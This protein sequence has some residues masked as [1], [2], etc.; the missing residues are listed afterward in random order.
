MHW[1][2]S[3]DDTQ[4]QQ[5]P[6]QRQALSRM[7][8]RVQKGKPHVGK[9]LVDIDNV[10][11]YAIPSLA[12]KSEKTETKRKELLI[13]DEVGK[14]EM[15]C[16]QFIPAVEQL[17]SNKKQNQIVLGTIPTP[18]Y[19]RVI[20]AVEDIRARED[21]LV[22]HVTKANRDDLTV[23]LQQGI[24]DIF[25]NPAAQ[26]HRMLRSL[27]EPFAYTRPIGASSM[28]GSGGTAQV[29]KKETD[30]PSKKVF[31]SKACG[32]LVSGKV[33]P[34]ILILGET[35]SP[36]PPNNDTQYSY[37]ERSMWIVLGRMFDVSYKPIKDVEAASEEELAT[38]ENL[39]QKALSYGICV[40]DVLANVHEKS[41]GQKKS[42]DTDN[43]P[44]DID[45]FMKRY[46]SVGMI[47][48]IGQKAGARY[49]SFPRSSKVK[50]VTLP[51][52]SPANARLTVDEKADAW[53]TAMSNVIPGL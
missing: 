30:A 23:I 21:V 38:F 40:W 28:H 27:L 46:P 6:P 17:L 47:G 36:L 4:Q 51:S 53:K 49:S 29:R 16:P 10:Q 14:M 11:M 5:Q 41:R 15:L 39:K 50:L 34:K 18:R 33:K 22:I 9:Y 24:Q 43:M 26:D 25:Q 12:S 45:A 42:T 48:F 2:S 19:G 1:S 3:D 7:V 31:V 37:C 32:P 44:N 13:V 20:S 35:A 52:S 8:D